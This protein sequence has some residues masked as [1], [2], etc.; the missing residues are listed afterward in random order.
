MLLAAW[1][2][3]T[4]LF[5]CS[6]GALH[7][8]FFGRFQITDVGLYR[9]I[10]DAV[11][12]GQIPFWDFKLGYP[13]GALP[14]FILPSLGHPSEYRQIFEFLMLQCG[15]LAIG[16]A[17]LTLRAVGARASRMFATAAFIGLAPLALGSV[18]LSRYDLWPAALTAAA[19][20]ALSNGRGRLGCSMLA[21][22]TAAKAYSLVLL[23]L[24]LLEI[25]RRRGRGEARK[26]LGVFVLTL[27]PLVL[28][29][30]FG[31]N[32]LQHAGTAQ[33]GRALQIESLGSSLL[34]AAHR[35][36][37]YRPTVVNGPG[38]QDLAGGLPHAVASITTV[39]QLAAVVI[40]WILF[41]RS[42]RSR[43]VLLLAC[44]GAV[45][46]FVVFGR[47]LSPQYLVWL[48]PLVP[49]LAGRVGLTASGILGAV[50][51]LTQ[52]WFPKRYFELVGLGRVDWFLV[53]RNALLVVLFVLLAVALWRQRASAGPIVQEQT[54][55]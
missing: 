45:V 33:A 17:L 55:S 2:L 12:A 53:A 51:V 13:P 21:V 10:G 28:P 7:G 46:A 23:P 27:A 43:E 18:V 6:W 44:A 37:I 47:V 36:G 38:S 24:A 39:A 25:A 48:L 30:A 42:D 5:G 54:Y 31:G 49:L 22:A 11:L 9:D 26:G 40:V 32:G 15:V 52:V 16:L 34:L 1:A 41:A 4:L 50:L 20:A 19:I 35:L 3:G 14:V 29:F 8:Y